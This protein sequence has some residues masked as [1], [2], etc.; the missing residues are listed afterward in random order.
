MEEYPHRGGFEIKMADFNQAIKW[1]REGKK[2]R[3]SGWVKGSVLHNERGRILFGSEN[4]TLLSCLPNLEATD[5]EIYCEEHNFS[6]YHIRNRLECDSTCTETCSNCGIEKPEETK[7]KT[8]KDL[9]CLNK[10][11]DHRT[12]GDF[13]IVRKSDLKQEAIKWVKYDIEVWR[14]HAI[15]EGMTK[16]QIREV[17]NQAVRTRQFWKDR[18]NITEEDLK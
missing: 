4:T 8:L 3:R 10:T 16:E 11:H 14:N 13:C 6:C 5:W 15:P 7:L 1:L 18:F 2:V 17:H 12:R 9:G